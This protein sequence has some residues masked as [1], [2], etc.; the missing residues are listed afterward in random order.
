[1]QSILVG[2]CFVPALMGIA[3]Q[4]YIQNIHESHRWKAKIL[5]GLFQEQILMIDGSIVSKELLAHPKKQLMSM[6][7]LSAAN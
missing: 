5:A 7:W 1:M 3:L 2:Q 6:L 4:R